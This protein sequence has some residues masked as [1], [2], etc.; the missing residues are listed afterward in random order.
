MGHTSATPG[1]SHEK[2]WFGRQEM[3]AILSHYGRLVASGA[4]KDYAIDMLSDR[5]VFAI[6]RRAAE[7]PSWR[8]EKVPALARKQGAYVVYGMAGQV[9]R[10][11]HDLA[12]ALRVLESAKLRVV[13]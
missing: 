3:D 13:K 9:L 7:A 8:I 5:A 6:Y 11:G 12:Q 2:V 10:R 1:D 4:A